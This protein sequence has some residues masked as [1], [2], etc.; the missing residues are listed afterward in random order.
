VVRPTSIRYVW[1]VTVASAAKLIVFAGGNNVDD[2]KRFVF[3][4]AD[5]RVVATSSRIPA[6]GKHSISPDGQW[7]A[8]TYEASV[9]GKWT[10][11]QTRG[12]TGV[13]LG[14]AAGNIAANAFVW[15]RDS[16]RLAIIMQATGSDMGAT[17]ATAGLY[18]H[19]TGRRRSFRRVVRG[20]VWNVSWSPTGKRIAY[21]AAG[22]LY[23][24]PVVGGSPV[25]IIPSA[26]SVSWSPDGTRLAYALEG[27][28][29][30]VKAS[31]GRSSAITPAD[32]YAYPIWSPDG[33]LI[34]FERARNVFS[35]AP[36]CPSD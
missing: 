10:G 12:G 9:A 27:A 4:N 18:V 32:G 21:V 29:F 11:V 2:Y 20:N 25:R 26:D 19:E 1:D 8:T 7:I 30:T 28:V 15:S 33:K 17:P 5:G 22:G 34:A 13:G 36:A 6:S 31:G 3:V 23:T 24:V 35:A 14:G 16:T